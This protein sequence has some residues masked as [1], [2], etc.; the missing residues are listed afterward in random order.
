MNSLKTFIR[1]TGVMI[2]LQG[3]RAAIFV[4]GFTLLGGQ[5]SGLYLNLLR[6]IT[7]IIT[8]GFF[9]LVFRPKFDQ[10]GF[11]LKELHKAW[12]IAVPIL[13]AL[14]GAL[15][16]TSLF[17]SES[18]S[19]NYELLIENLVN[20]VIIVSWEE[21][22]FR[23]YF[24][25]KIEDSTS[26]LPGITAWIIT[27]ILFSLW[28]LGYFDYFWFVAHRKFPNYTIAEWIPDRLL[29]GLVF[30]IVTG[31]LRL[32]SNNI[33]VSMIFHGIKNLFGR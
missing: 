17:V 25:K 8:T 7:F 27:A 21:F 2:L 23:G 13:G 16:C 26:R 10:I 22:V 12:K 1:L 6:G 19:L 11:S 18:A 29:I 9:I 24:W 4:S 28:H 14:W 20:S 3:F 33:Y 32:W 15:V 5:T 30:G 31:G